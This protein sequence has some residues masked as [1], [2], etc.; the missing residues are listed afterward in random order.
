MGLRREYLDY[1][2]ESVRATLGDLRGRQMLEL[3]NQRI[4]R[5][6]GVAARTGKAYF[7]QLGAVHTSLDF[8]GA[9][10][11]IALDLSQ[12][13]DKPE[14]N[15][16]FDIITNAGTTEHVE[17]Y[18]AQYEC[19]ANIH[20]WVKR[21]GIVVHIVPSIEELA[22]NGR[23]R[24]HCNNYY[25]QRFFERFAAVNGYELVSTRVIRELRAACLRRLVEQPFE[26]DRAAFLQ[27]I[28]R[29]EGGI[30]YHRADDPERWQPRN[31]ARRW[32]RKIGIR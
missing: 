2:E 14:W 10:G 22:A 25:S 28:T 5:S 13:I 30:V 23:W 16:L 15:G 8:N 19:F 3:G 29:K 24:G 9:D 32:L 6:A 21:G 1:I 27:H 17:P 12:R 18:A 31:V 7:T 26:T 20:G 11:A 4:P